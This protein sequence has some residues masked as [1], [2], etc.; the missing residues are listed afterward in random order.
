VDARVRGRLG[1]EW[2]GTA[3]V[4]LTRGRLAGVEVDQLRLPFAFA[5]APFRGNGHLELEE[6]SSQVA[7]GRMTTRASLTFGS[8]S[9]LEGQVRFTEVDIRTLLTPFTEQAQNASGRMTGQIDFGGTELRSI[10]DLN[11]TMQAD[12]RQTRAAGIPVLGQLLPFLLPIQSSG[13][14]FSSGDLRARLSR[15]VIRIQRLTLQGT[16]GRLFIEGNITVEGRLNLDVT[17]A[18]GGPTVNPVLFN[19]IIQR[20]PIVGPVPVGLL[21]QARNLLATWAIHLRVTG[22]IRSP[23]IQVEPLSIVSEN[24]FRFFFPNRT[25]FSSP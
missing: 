20:V 11:A 12:L 23:S 18:T 3:E 16:S 1:R 25:N 21:L 24:L 6:S 2:V 9:R 10:D 14:A 4:T 8:G 15:S 22:T 7:F 13:A 19:Q 17:A 5:V